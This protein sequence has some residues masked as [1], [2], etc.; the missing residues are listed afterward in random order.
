MLQC[1]RTELTDN[2]ACADKFIHDVLKSLQTS[3]ERRSL[4][5]V[6]TYMMGKSTKKTNRSIFLERAR[7]FPL[8][9]LFP[10]II[11]MK[12]LGRKCVSLSAVSGKRKV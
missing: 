12:K 9:E 11:M 2:R 4:H 5:I 8:P 3:G 6:M 7:F 1:G 10:F